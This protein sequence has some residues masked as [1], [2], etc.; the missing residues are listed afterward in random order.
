VLAGVATTGAT[1]A[2]LG[3]AYAAK[4]GRIVAAATAEG[5]AYAT[6]QQ[7]TDRVGPRL[8]GSPGAEA[9][10]RWAVERLKADGLEARTEAVMVPHW[11]RGEETAAIVAPVS[12]KLVV[13]AL[14]GSDPTPAAGLTAEVVEAAS[15]EE[16]KALGAEKVKGKIVLF[17]KAMPNAAA[18][19]TTHPLRTHGAS[20]AA[21]LGAVASLVRSL[22]TYSMRN[23]HTGAMDYDEGVPHIPAGALAAEDAELI[24][25]LLA[26]GDTVRV[27]LRLGC[28]S[29]PDVPSANVVADL[30]GR[31]KPQEIV[32]I[33]AHLDSW[34]LATG[35]IDDGAGVAMVMES[36]RLL[37]ALGLQPRRT[38]R[39]V[40]FMNEENGLRGGRGYAEAHRGE[41]AQHVAAL[42]SDSGGAR[43]LGI[44]SNT[45]T[46]GLALLTPIGALLKD[47]GADSVRAGEGGADI[48][49]MRTG[50][51]PMLGLDVD[52]THYFDWH[53]SPAD[54]LDKIDPKELAQDAATMAVYAYVLADM[55]QTLPRPAA[56]EAARP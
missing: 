15:F 44:R 12:Q 13:T 46:E 42:E 23:P 34:D 38:I 24:H 37:K 3:E 1:A 48:S 21:R 31:E 32:L 55:P 52:S 25:R 27:Q 6:L 35:A 33:G 8:S 20:E 19:G 9:A 47:I 22:G 41:L 17:N 50:G 56:S 30:R 26:A 4:A 43:P 28:R 54:T 36:L 16:L 53:H 7:L 10:V 14:G 29:L 5:R 2:E 45:G 51:V 49:P 40:L 18:Y 39:G 11:E